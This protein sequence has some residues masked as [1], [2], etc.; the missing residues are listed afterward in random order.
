MT[1]DHLGVW[2]LAFAVFCWLI[3]LITG[4][5]LWR[6]RTDRARAINERIS[7]IGLLHT[8]VNNRLSERRE[9]SRIDWLAH[10]LGRSWIAQRIDRLLAV[11][12]SDARLDVF[13]VSIAGAAIVVGSALAYLTGSSVIVL[14]GVLVVVALPFFYLRF[15][16]R[17]RAAVFEKQLP[18]V[19]DF[20]SRAMQA[21]HAFGA[22]IEMAASEAPQPIGA[23]FAKAH[24]Q[25][26]HGVPIQKA[27]SDLA[28]R[29]DSA[30][31]NFFAAAVSI[32]HEV[33]GDLAALLNNLAALIRSRMEM[34][35]SLKAITAEGRLSAKILVV[36][37]F[38][39]AAV[40]FVLQPEMVSVLWQTEAGQ[41]LLTAAGVL[42]L[43]G[44]LWI[45]RIIQFRA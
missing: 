8:T 26:N 27:L 21:G 33:G 14:L 34:R 30:D 20:I 35:E 22:A 42:M 19:L 32:N 38:V 3:A 11:A 7:Q 17:R 18:N 25:M 43:L 45:N 29:I 12:G 31:L 2:L 6:A 4:V 40:F 23:E 39:I 5:R 28:N 13:L 15:A 36:L 9:L 41:D 10:Y 24:A 1:M 37:P 16:K 44:I